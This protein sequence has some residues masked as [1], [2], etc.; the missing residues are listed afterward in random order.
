MHT[1]QEQVLECWTCWCVNFALCSVLDEDSAF[2]LLTKSV[3]DI[4]ELL[5]GRVDLLL[6]IYDAG[7]V[8]SSL[9]RG[10]KMRMARP[11]IV[12]YCSCIAVEDGSSERKK[13]HPTGFRPQA[14]FFL[15][16]PCDEEEDY[17]E[18]GYDEGNTLLCF[19]KACC[20]CLGGID[21]SGQ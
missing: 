17:D 15:L 1:V 12:W 4:E 6:R 14:I 9:F 20:M 5:S 2:Q 18:A 11:S 21:K 16:L 7:I 13:N 8:G 3:A 19:W 10:C